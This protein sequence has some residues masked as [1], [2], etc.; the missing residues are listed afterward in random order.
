MLNAGNLNTR[1]RIQRLTTGNT[2]S[3]WGAEKTWETIRDVWA[4]AW[5][6]SGGEAPGPSGQVGETIFKVIIRHQPDL[7]T[8]DRLILVSVDKTLD[9]VSIADRT[10]KGV[11]FEVSCKE[12][13]A[14]G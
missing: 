7:T 3:Q 9:I 5:S 11:T 14:H 2:T 10:G 6:E 13:Q 8:R 1:V 4:Q 12:H